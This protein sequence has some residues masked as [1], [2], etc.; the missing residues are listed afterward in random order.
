MAVGVSNDNVNV[1]GNARQG[2]H[3]AHADVAPAGKHSD[4]GSIKRVGEANVNENENNSV[5]R[6]TRRNT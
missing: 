4:S 1:N 3:E 5:R 6:F 2:D